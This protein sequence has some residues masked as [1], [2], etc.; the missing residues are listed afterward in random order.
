MSQLGSQYNENIKKSK[1]SQHVNV[2]NF[3]KK[4]GKSAY[5][6]ENTTNSILKVIIFSLYANCSVSTQKDKVKSSLSVETVIYEKVTILSNLGRDISI[7][8]GNFA[9][10]WG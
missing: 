9:N 8:S 1:S 10:P 4:A 3:D 5:I 6:C 2:L 7:P